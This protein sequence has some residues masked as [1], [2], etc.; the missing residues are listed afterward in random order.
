M[1]RP[2]LALLALVLSPSIQA[3][4][5][6]TLKSCLETGLERNYSIRIIRNEQQISDN[7]ATLANAGYLPTLDLTAGYTGNLDNSRTTP[8]EGEAYSENGNYDQTVN[9]GLALNWTIFEG[10]RIQTDYKR[11]VELQRQ[12]ELQTRI[13]I[14]DFVANLTA[15]YYNFIQQKIRLQNFRYAMMLS[16]ERLRIVETRKQVGNSSLLE[17]Y[18]ARV[19]FNADSSQYTNQQQ[20]VRTSL[21]ALNEMMVNADVNTPLQ[22][23]DTAIFVNEHLDLA[24]LETGTLHTNASLLMAA[25][26][27]T[28]AE[29]D[30]KTVQARNYP[31][32]T[33]KSGYGYTLNRYGS[34]T[35]RQRRTFGLD[36]G[37]SV[38]FT[39][40]DGNRRREQRNARIEIDNARLAQAQLEQ[41]LRASLA[42]FWQAYR[43][44]LDIIHLE[45]EN[46]VT[47]Q[48]NY[49]TAMERYQLGDL[50][51]IE[52]REAQQSLLDAE[53]R[54]L[55]AEYNTKLCEISLLQISGNILSYMQ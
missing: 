33:L 7:N 42:D 35:T 18:Q 49:D 27:Q 20:L 9:A 41:S 17:V 19:D 44:N 6:C 34:G 12:G 43:N 14:E 47:A 28:L 2:I 23:M 21:I 54:L 22:I 48:I 5:I 24:E 10:F 46:L 45:R 52:M 3:Q 32:V 36:A 15:E 16:K 25:R 31:Y 55:T 13:A 37:L 30:L 53:E 39:I 11:L 1:K 26:D 4:E 50:A 40:F 38:G 8:R 29:L 51:G